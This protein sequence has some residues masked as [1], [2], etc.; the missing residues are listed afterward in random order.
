MLQLWPN[1]DYSVRRT[2]IASW[3]VHY[4]GHDDYSLETGRRP[5]QKS[6]PLPIFTRIRVVK[7][8]TEIFML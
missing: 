3:E 6:S 8:D 7:N 5:I 1:H 2:A 4:V